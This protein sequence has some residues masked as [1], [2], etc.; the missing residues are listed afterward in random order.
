MLKLFVFLFLNE[1]FNF[2]LIYSNISAVGVWFLLFLEVHIFLKNLNI[3][4]EI[5]KK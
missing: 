1:L 4:F 2:S 3:R 5:V